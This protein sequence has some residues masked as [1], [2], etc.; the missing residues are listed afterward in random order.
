MQIIPP[1]TVTDTMLTS[2]NVLEAGLVAWSSGTT[3][4]AG[5]QVK[6]L[7]GSSLETVYESLVGSNLNHAP[8]ASPTFWKQISIFYDAWSSGVTYVA[9]D[10][11]SV[12]TTNSH[13][14]Y[15]SLQASNLNHAVTD[16]AW[17]Q[18]A[19]VTNTW[20]SFDLYR[21]T[22][23]VRASPYTFTVT[24]GIRI[25]SL[26]AVGMVADSITI[27]IM[28]GASV[29]YNETINLSTRN[30]LDWLSYYFGRFGTKDSLARFNL[31]MY[32]NA[33]ITVTLTRTS[34]NVSLGGF[35]IGVAQYIGRAQ[36]Q[37]Q[38]D[39]KNY[40][41]VE[42][43]NSGN[44]T[45]IPKRAVPKTNQVVKVAKAYVP[46]IIDLRESLD[47]VP[48]YWSA[49]DDDTSP[50]FKALQILGFYTKFVIGVDFPDEA[51]I[52]LELEEI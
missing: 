1:I 43:D 35:G 22:K 29:V 21:N 13:R 27:T 39:S 7:T 46:T 31:P 19:G 50:Y 10:I 32:M 52:Q 48:A 11:V 44:A 20:A 24:P 34:G 45:L 28:S 18:D 38:S 23:T 4:A 2:T 36:Y 8:A 33:V 12:I 40:S 16:P 25:N 6:V 42:R 17:W 5:N 26:F 49:L 14:L 51:Q 30:T 3:Y 15:Q 41:V 37:A 47:A 9:G